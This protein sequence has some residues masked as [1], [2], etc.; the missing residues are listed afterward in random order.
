MYVHECLHVENRL[1]IPPCFL[2]LQNLL[3]S[4]HCY[5]CLNACYAYQLLLGRFILFPLWRSSPP[6]LFLYH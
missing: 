5:L 4:A 6:A 3:P 1:R 2:L